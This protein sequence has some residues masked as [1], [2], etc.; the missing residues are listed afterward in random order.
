MAQYLISIHKQILGC[1]IERALEGAPKPPSLLALPTFYD[2][3]QED[4]YLFLENHKP[5][6]DA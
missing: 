6:N 5:L 2:V 4:V 1:E 3:I